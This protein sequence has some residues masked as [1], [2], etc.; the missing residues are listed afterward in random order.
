MPPQI[1]EL[2]TSPM[3]RDHASMHLRPKLPAQVM[4][5]RRRW[6]TT[7]EADTDPIPWVWTV[8]LRTAFERIIDDA[9]SMEPQA[10]RFAVDVEFRRRREAGGPNDR[11]V[12]G[13]LLRTGGNL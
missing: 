9:I 8:W 2:A 3:S 7:E 6:I 11:G 5:V 13:R 10:D 4:T 12:P 1:A